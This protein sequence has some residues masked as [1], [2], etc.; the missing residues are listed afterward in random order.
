MQNSPRL[1]Y[2]VAFVTRVVKHWVEQEV[3]QWS[4][5]Q[6]GEVLLKIHK[7]GTL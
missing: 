6:K 5:I 2:I 7:P 1:V 4:T 3:A